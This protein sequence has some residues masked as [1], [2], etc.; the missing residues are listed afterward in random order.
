MKINPKCA[1]AYLCKCRWR[2]DRSEEFETAW[3]AGEFKDNKDIKQAMRFAT[4]DLKTWLDS[5]KKRTDAAKEKDRA[6]RAAAVEPLR[7][8]RERIAPANKL[9]AMQLDPKCLYG[10]RKD[11]RVLAAGNSVFN[12]AI[13]KW[14][15]V[16]ELATGRNH[17]VALRRN[18]TVLATGENKN[19]QCNVSNWTDVVAI[20]AGAYHTVGLPR[21]GTVLATRIIQDRSELRCDYGQSNISDWKGIV[22]VFT[23]DC[24]TVG[25]RSDGTICLEG[26]QNY[27][28]QWRKWKDIVSVL[29]CTDVLFGLR[30]DG[31]V[32]AC[33][34]KNYISKR[35]AFDE[36]RAKSRIVQW[37]YDCEEVLEWRNIIALYVAHA[38]VNNLSSRQKVFGLRADGTLVCTRSDPPTWRNVVALENHSYPNLFG[39]SADGTIYRTEYKP[40][41]YDSDTKDP[42]GHVADWKLFDN[43]DTL[44]Q[45]R[46]EA[47]EHAEQ[48]R[49]EA[50]ERARKA[51]ERAERERQERIAAIN[52]EQAA[53]QTELPNL[54]GLFSGKRRK[55]IETRLAEIDAELKKLQ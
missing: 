23:N 41:L 53:L 1:E 27:D 44:Q 6:K 26:E 32:I 40:P 19:G 48:E 49:K 42:L 16:T 17:L 36:E 20:A 7:L 47:F 18:G 51:A 30:M 46:E 2:P 34:D 10:I 5:L 29:P 28:G 52:S 13:A 15:D 31:T 38:N 12:S 50:E 25:L 43:I 37:G 35:F 54:K 55:E 33:I 39:L 14:T 8:A 21:D 4:G 24:T 3:F 45:E 22:S 9:L 11:G